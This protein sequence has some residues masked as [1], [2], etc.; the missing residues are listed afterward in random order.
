MKFNK[1]LI[2]V[3][4]AGTMALP[5]TAC[6]PPENNSIPQNKVKI[7]IGDVI[8]VKEGNREFE[9][10]FNGVEYRQEVYSTS[11]EMYKSCLPDIENE[12]Y[13]CAEIQIKNVGSNMVSH[14]IFEHD[15]V[16]TIKLSFDGEHCFDMQPLDLKSPILSSV[17]LVEPLKACEIW[18]V[19]SVPNKALSTPCEISF[20]VGGTTYLFS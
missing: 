15:S 5:F 17:W 3:L 1:F 2:A 12:T 16:N 6:S 8:N 18:F 10:H 11:D 13:I 4:T 9:I 20:T 7:N 19:K 14:S